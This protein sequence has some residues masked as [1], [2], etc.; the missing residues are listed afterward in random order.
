MQDILL[1][2]V[3]IAVDIEWLIFY[4]VSLLLTSLPFYVMLN[5]HT[6]NK[7]RYIFWPRCAPGPM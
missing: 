7:H 5:G 6:A 1:T 4:H 2:I 3:I